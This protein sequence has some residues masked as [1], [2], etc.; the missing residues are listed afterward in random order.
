MEDKKMFELGLG[1]PTGTDKI[2][3]GK[4]GSVYKN[5]TVDDFKTIMQGDIADHKTLSFE[6]GAWDM[7]S[8]SNVSV[9]IN[10]T[11]GYIPVP[12]MPNKIRGIS[13][14]ILDDNDVNSS[15]FLSVQG[16]TA[17]SDQPQ[18]FVYHIEYIFATTYVKLTRRNDSY[19][20]SGDY[21]KVQNPDTSPYNRGWV[22]I[23]YIE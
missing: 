12:I 2:V 13:V 5:I 19:F 7:S 10:T 9:V 14:M 1:T 21:N 8:T 23:T 20:D 17:A 6:I 16:G 18:I 11:S 3:F 15:D 22:T 4:N